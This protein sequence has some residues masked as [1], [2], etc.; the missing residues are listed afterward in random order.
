MLF[1]AMYPPIIRT[2]YFTILSYSYRLPRISP[3]I[4][5]I[6]WVIDYISIS[7]TYHIQGISENTTGNEHNYYAQDDFT[8]CL[9]N[10]ISISNWNHCHRDEVKPL[11]I[12]HTPIWILNVTFIHPRVVSELVVYPAYVIR[13][14]ENEKSSISLENFIKNCF[15][16]G[17]SFLTKINPD[18]REHMSN[19]QKVKEQFYWS[20]H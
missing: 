8:A 9:G 1:L 10:N 18:A 12:L 15:A 20:K 4:L 7:F 5:L 11:Q 13:K 2:C 14:D 6:N 16:K 17:N 3:E 19:E